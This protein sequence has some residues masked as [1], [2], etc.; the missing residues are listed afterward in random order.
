MREPFLFGHIAPARY[1]VGPLAGFVD[2]FATWLGQQHY[3]RESA[4]HKIRLVADLS[5]W[6]QR[7][8]LG[9]ESLN[10]SS[11]SRFFRHRRCRYDPV[12]IGDVAAVEQLMD[13]LRDRGAIPRPVRQDPPTPSHPIERE[14]A[15]YLTQE[16]RLSTATLHNTVPYVRRFLVERFGTGAVC[17]P[18][19]GASDIH[20]FVLRHAHAQS[21]SR[22]KLM[23]GALRSFFRFLHLRGDIASDLAA[24]V[25]TVASWRLSGLPNAIGPDEVRRLLRSCNRRTP[26]G[27]RDYAVLLLLA[28]LGLRAGEVAA[29]SLDDIDW[30]AGRMTIHGKGARRDQLPLPKDVGEALVAY[31]RRGRPPCPSRRIFLTARAPIRDV[32][33][34]RVV[35]DIVRRAFQRAGLNSPHKGAHVLRHSL[36]T[37]MLRRGSS[38]AE[39]G[40]ILR[41][42]RVDTTAI[43]AKVDL[44]ALSAL[45]RPWPGGAA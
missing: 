41:H 5:R 14:F 16:R 33:E 18:E 23:V 40:E 19:I 1:R 32:V 43:Y 30:E 11:V 20:R 44:T 2:L 26:T 39:I 36:A 42:Q 15:L 27:R 34:R 37:D 17:L 28:R 12:R 21:P 22:A 29:L 10:E 6:L 45:A 13:L 8:R 7:R 3:R 31:L 25:P 35:G 24:A 4:R 9:V 38:L